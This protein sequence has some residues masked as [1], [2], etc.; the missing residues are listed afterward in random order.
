VKDLL[1][2]ALFKK[3]LQAFM[4]RW[5]GKHP[6]PWDFFN[7]MN[8][9]SGRNLDWFWNNWY[10]SNGY[11]DIAL[12]SVAKSA[13]GYTIVLDNVGGMAAPVSLRA[14]YSDGS[15]EIVHETPAIWA[16]NQARSTVRL[17]TRKTLAAVKLEHGIWMDADTTNDSWHAGGSPH[18]H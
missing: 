1:G 3:S 2:D 14:E 7:T 4:D 8:D 12:K 10:F 6:I 13:G 11:I 5:H 9:V 15:A 18:T 17:A 16:A